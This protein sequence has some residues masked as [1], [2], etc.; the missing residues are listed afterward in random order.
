MGNEDMNN[1]IRN[2]WEKSDVRLAW[3]GW[4]DCEQV[5][6]HAGSRLVPAVSGMENWLAPDIL[7]SLSLPWWFPLYRSIYLFL[8]LA[9]TIT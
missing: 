7:I 4:E 9:Y 8:V 5:L 2:G 1:V 3:L 6:L